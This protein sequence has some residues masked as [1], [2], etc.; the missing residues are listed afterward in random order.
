[1]KIVKM[2]YDPEYS[3]KVKESEVKRQYNYFKLKKYTNKTYDEFKN[4]NFRSLRY[5]LI[6]Y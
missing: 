6:I 4:D 2:Y 3:R 1:M 5:K